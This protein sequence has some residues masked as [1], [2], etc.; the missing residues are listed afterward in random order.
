MK[1]ADILPGAVTLMSSALAAQSP[2]AVQ[3]AA[4]LVVAETFTLPSA[5]LN[6][7]RRI[8]VDLPPACAMPACRASGTRPSSTQRRWL[9]FERPSHPRNSRSRT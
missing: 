8:N 9:R 5:T 3:P 4:S 6:E 1:G 2:P 7:T